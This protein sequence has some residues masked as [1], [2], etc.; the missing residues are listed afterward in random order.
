M[1]RTVCV[2]LT[3][4]RSILQ[5]C[6]SAPHGRAIRNA[7]VDVGVEGFVIF[8]STRAD[9][10]NGRCA[11]RSILQMMT[12]GGASSE[13]RAVSRDFRFQ[14]ARLPLSPPARVADR[15]RFPEI[16]KSG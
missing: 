9:L 13:G 8:R 16:R 6:P 7:Q 4:A 11:R 2:M 3:A 10:E 5:K 12:V 14:F 15:G 1:T